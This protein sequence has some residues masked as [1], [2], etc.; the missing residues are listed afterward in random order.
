MSEVSNILVERDGHVL[1]I[2]I[3]RPDKRNSLT[4]EMMVD[5]ANALTTLSDDPELRAGVLYGEGEHFTS[6]LDLM[7][8]VPYLSGKIPLLKHLQ[9]TRCS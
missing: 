6:G 7:Q 1:L 8:F 3:N 4:P 5:L 9:S 2:G